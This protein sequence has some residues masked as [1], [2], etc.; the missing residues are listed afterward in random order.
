MGKRTKA[1]Q[2]LLH[3]RWHLSA[4]G[5]PGEHPDRHWGC[6]SVLQECPMQPSYRQSRWLHRLPLL[7]ST[8]IPSGATTVRF[9]V[10]VIPSVHK[11][12]G[13]GVR[14]DTE[15]SPFFR[16]GLSETHDSSLCSGIIDL[17]NVPMETG[18]RRYVDDGTVF[19][20]FA[21]RVCYYTTMTTGPSKLE[22]TLTRK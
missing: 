21:L 18:Y 20:A 7:Q 4:E 9:G 22:R 11:T 16:D 12:I 19:R 6:F 8:Y 1:C 5:C 10:C 15:W 17:A 2:R 3:Q 13:N 14:A